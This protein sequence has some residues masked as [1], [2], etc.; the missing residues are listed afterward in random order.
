MKDKSLPIRVA[1]KLTDKHIHLNN[2]S[3]IKVKYA[4]QIFSHTVGASVWMHTIICN[5]NSTAALQI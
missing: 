4:A 1:P 5:G 3:K 2:F